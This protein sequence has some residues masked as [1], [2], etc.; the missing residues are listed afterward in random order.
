MMGKSKEQAAAAFDAKPARITKI[1]RIVELMR[2]PQ[3]ATS[4]QMMEATGWQA[5]SVRGAV[6]GQVRKT[7]SLPVVT[8][9]TE[10]GTV[11]RI[12]EAAG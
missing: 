2:R 7:L 9:K 1:R 11:Y 4:I 6:A 12:V 10:A 5:H 8:E 3:G